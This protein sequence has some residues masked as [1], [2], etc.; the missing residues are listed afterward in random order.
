MKTKKPETFRLEPEVDRKIE[1]E[2]QRILETSR[3]N[4]MHL[5]EQNRP[6]LR[7]DRLLP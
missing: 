3:K 4:A 6:E 2:H 7:G 5:A 1:S